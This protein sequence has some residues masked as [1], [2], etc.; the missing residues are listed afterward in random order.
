M[1]IVLFDDLVGD[2]AATYRAVIE[3]LDVDPTF[4]PD[5]A[6]HNESKRVRSGALQRL[7]FNP[8]GPVR[9][10][11]GSRMAS[12]SIEP[13]PRPAPDNTRPA[14][15]SAGCSCVACIRSNVRWAARFPWVR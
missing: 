12:L 1:H 6:V 9:G 3:F 11:D 13:V 8:P 5:F 15:S 7:I 4:Q 10:A 2:T 14:V